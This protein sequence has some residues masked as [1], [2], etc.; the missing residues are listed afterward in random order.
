MKYES[1]T[2]DAR[3]FGLAASSIAA[4]LTTVCALALTV[5]P[6]ATTAVASA[7]IHLDLSEMSRTLSWGIYLESLLGWTIGAGL[8]FWSAAALY[9]R[10]VG[11]PEVVPSS[12][13]AFSPR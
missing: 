9:N 6:R 2:L 13:T 5:A 1:K 10:F 12:Q 4:I 8:V 11:Q 3:A 7:L